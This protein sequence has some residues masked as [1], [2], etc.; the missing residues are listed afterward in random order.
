[1]LPVLNI[2]DLRI[3]WTDASGDH[4]IVDGVSLHINAGEILGVV[5]ACTT[6]IRRTI[7]HMFSVVETS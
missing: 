1:M 4:V 6:Q 5:G 3:G 7:T 2:Q